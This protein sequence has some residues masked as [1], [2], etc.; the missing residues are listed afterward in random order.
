LRY[1]PQD[2]FAEE[3]AKQG[4]QTPQDGYLIEDAELEQTQ[5]TFQK[6]FSQ[7]TRSAVRQ[8]AIYFLIWRDY[9]TAPPQATVAGVEA[10]NARRVQAIHELQREFAVKKLPDLAKAIGWS[11]ATITKQ[12]DEIPVVSRVHTEE[13]KDHVARVV[14][15]AR[16]G[17]SQELQRIAASL[18][19]L[20]VSG[21]GI[22]AFLLVL[23]FVF[24]LFTRTA[25]AQIDGVEVQEEGVRVRRGSGGYFYI[26]FI[27]TP[28]TCLGD[29]TLQNKV[30][31]T[32]TGGGAT[33]HE[34]LSATHTDTT[35]VAV[36]RG[37]L[38]VGKNVTP[39]WESLTV[40]GA[41][42]CLASDGTDVSWAACGGAAWENEEGV[43]GTINGSNVDFSINY[44]PS[45]VTALRLV[46]NGLTLRSGAGNDFTISGAAITMNYA[47]TAGSNFTAWYQHL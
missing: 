5:A 30:N 8:R 35:A 26:N 31:C 12:V 44:A 47:P 21:F 28:A 39:K 15:T 11:T 40:G 3:L 1:F 37:A 9:A 7:E 25:K 24:L 34:I 20:V 46:L 43:A 16:A 17:Q 4:L 33:T 38:M 13:V 41:G 32:F 22:L 18:R 10:T 36:T 27:G 42:T 6:E 2:D 14:I 45:P 29:P 19:R 23:I